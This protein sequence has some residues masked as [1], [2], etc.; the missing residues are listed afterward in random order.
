MAPEVDLL[1]SQH[2]E[3]LRQSG[4]ALDV[5]H[6]RGYRTVVDPTELEQLGFSVECC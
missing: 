1:S 4:I 2:L 3:H 5:I 6:E